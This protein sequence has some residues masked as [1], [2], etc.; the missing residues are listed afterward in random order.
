[1]DASL[2]FGVLEALLG[3]EV[4]SKQ[5]VVRPITEVELSVLHRLPSVITEAVNSSWDVSGHSPFAF[6]GWR[7]RFS[8]ADLNAAEFITVTIRL[9]LR[10]REG[11]ISLLL[12][13]RIT[14]AAEQVGAD[15]DAQAPTATQGQ[16][17]VLARLRA[18]LLTLDARLEGSTLRL[19]DL[20][21][22]KT[23]DLIRLDQPLDKPLAVL[24]NGAPRLQGSLIE[25]KTKKSLAISSL[26]GRTL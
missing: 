9:A 22:L 6:S 16:R 19:E 2:A 11:N 12:P 8:P 14:Q 13:R 26:L 25:S 18:A 4:G 1:M 5:E 3:A 24:V 10:G 15:V 17:T 21:D 20:M 7:R 23:G